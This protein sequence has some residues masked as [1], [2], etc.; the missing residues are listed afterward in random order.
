LVNPVTVKGDADPVATKLP[1]V[2]VALYPVIGAGYPALDGA[3]K[4]TV[5]DELPAVALTLVGAPGVVGQ[6]PFPVA[7]ICC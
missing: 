4:V 5:A 2:E 1:G 3:T 6:T 7:C